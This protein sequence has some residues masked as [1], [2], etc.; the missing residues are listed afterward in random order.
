MAKKIIK[1]SAKQLQ[2]IIA[3]EATR[4]RKVLELQKEREN[5]LSQLKEMYE[6]IELDELMGTSVSTATAPK[7]K[8]QLDPKQKNTENGELPTHSKADGMGFGGHRLT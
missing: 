6:V 3:E 4:Y 8:D 2:T 5:I 1:V 7:P